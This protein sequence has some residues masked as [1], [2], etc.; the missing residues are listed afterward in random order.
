M[1]DTEHPNSSCG[2][3]GRRSAKRNVSVAPE[4]L[5]GADPESSRRKHGVTAAVFSEWRGAVLASGG[6][7]LKIRQEHLVDERGRCMKSVIAELAVENELLRERTRRM[8]DEKPY[9]GWRSKK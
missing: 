6:G 2:G 9:L 8:E 3:K 7:G 5:R 1:S 4:L